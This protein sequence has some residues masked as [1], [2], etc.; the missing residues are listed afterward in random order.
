MCMQVQTAAALAHKVL[1][2]LSI[3]VKK[4]ASKALRAAYRK[5]LLPITAGAC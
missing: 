4:G 5:W 1:E 3:E 2:E